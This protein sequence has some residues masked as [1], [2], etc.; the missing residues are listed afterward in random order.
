MTP[1]G[2]GPGDMRT[3]LAV[4]DIVAGYRVESHVA[5]GGMAVVYKAR[6]VTLGRPVAL[7]LIAPEL[8]SNDRF[9]L[10]FMR[11]SE[12]AA[13]IDHPN[14]IPIYRAGEEDSRLYI[15][16][17]FVDGEDLGSALAREGPLAIDQLL[18]LFTQMAGALDA[19]HAGGLVHRDVKPGNVLLAG[20]SVDL[21]GR[22]VY[23]TDFGLTKQS[24]SLTGFT[25]AGHFLGTIQYVA[26]EQI[27]AGA[28]DAR[29]DVYSL[30]CL[31]YEALSGLPPYTA[32]HDAGVLWAHMAGPIPA[33]TDH[34]PELSAAVDE[35][36]AAAMAKEPDDRPDSCLAM[37]EELRRALVHGPPAVSG[38]TRVG[39]PAA[40]RP[41]DVDGPPLQHAAASWETDRLQDLGPRRV[42]S[43]TSEVEE[44]PPKRPP[45][46]PTEATSQ[47]SARPARPRVLALTAAAAV[48]TVLAGAGAWLAS[49][50]GGGGDWQRYSRTLAA[51]PISFDKPATWT[52]QP[53]GRL[54]AVFSPESLSS[55]FV[56]EDWTPAAAA[57]R[58]NTLVGLQVQVT[59]IPGYDVGDVNGL[60]DELGVLIPGTEVF[61]SVATTTV[62]GHSA[63][64]LDGTAQDP[65]GSARL[66]FTYYVVKIT[67]RTKLHLLFFCRP[68]D[69]AGEQSTFDRVV[70]SLDASPLRDG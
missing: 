11:E 27:S 46:G 7:K 22:H 2:P 21:A 35:V 3:T 8:A 34:R 69:F 42:T 51:A 36:V 60:R 45:A 56:S 4:G 50:G 67:A 5:R 58:R 52:G 57:R 37:V 10:R 24:S 25:T 48:L 55:L 13:A 18:P 19:A 6:D 43:A 20:H 63:A 61:N 70:R 68:Q 47:A 33:V 62:A 59:R 39:R 28:V 41:D 15:A 9:R 49:G 54:S 40:R 23:L 65:R 29:T 26:P 64:R 30:G 66:A 31:L 12:L 17:R 53:H 44:S 32:D 14:I 1:V 16:M 38:D